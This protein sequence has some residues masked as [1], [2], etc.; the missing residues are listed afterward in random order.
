MDPQHTGRVVVSQKAVGQEK[1]DPQE[2]G[3]STEDDS[4]QSPGQQQMREMN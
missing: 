1:W 2:Y 3:G 4:G